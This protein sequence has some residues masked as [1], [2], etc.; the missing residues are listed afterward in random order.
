M[1]KQMWISTI[2][3]LF[4]VP[5]NKLIGCFLVAWLDFWLVGWMFGWHVGWLVWWFVGWLGCLSAGCTK[6]TK[7]IFHKTWLENASLPR[8][9]LINFWYGFFRMDLDERYL[10]ELGGWYLLGLNRG[11]PFTKCH[12]GFI[13]NGAMEIYICSP[14]T[15]DWVPRCAEPP[16]CDER[17]KQMNAKTYL[18]WHPVHQKLDKHTYPTVSSCRVRYITL[19]VSVRRSEVNGG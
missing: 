4:L 5:T 8:I 13:K 14:K 19:G 6:P 7:H 3:I 17:K 16:L 12:C 9:D 10:A 18:G 1:T 11:L 2:P 15:Q